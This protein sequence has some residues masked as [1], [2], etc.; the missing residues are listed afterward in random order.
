MGDVPSTTRVWAANEAK[1][2]L[3]EREMKVPALEAFDVALKVL[4]CGICH[5]DLHLIDNDWRISEYPLVPGHEILGRVESLGTQ[6]SHLKVGDVVGVGW[7][8]HSCMECHYCH[9]GRENLCSHSAAT[10]VGR[11]GGFAQWHVTDS[12]FCFKIPENLVRAD[13]APLLCGGATVFSP[14]CDHVPKVSPWRTHVGVV[15]M[16]GLGHLGIK[17][18]SR[19]GYEVTAF[20]SSPHKSSDLKVLGAH[21]VVSSTNEADIIKAGR[22]LDLVLVTVPYDLPWNAYLKAL[23]PDGTL[24]FVGVPPAALSVPV[25]NILG[26]QL[27]ITGS[28]IAGR[29]RIE[30]MLEFCSRHSITAQSEVF[31]A[32]KVNDAIAAVRSGKVRYRAVL[33]F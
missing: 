29:A 12:R 11:P 16:G 9:T 28:S 7:Q 30:E 15:G 14:L 3:I 20:T 33:S 6:V 26:G 2:A 13:T 25:I 4:H 31:E 17:M 22:R 10:C 27:R 19:M 32:A 24:C 21:H 8:C 23:R 18:A 1:G 5:S